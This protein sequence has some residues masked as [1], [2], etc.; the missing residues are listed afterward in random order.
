[1]TNA[2]IQAAIYERIATLNKPTAYPGVNF[3]PP[4][5]G[6]WLEVIFQPNKPVQQGLSN[7]S[8][9][10]KRGLFTV[11]V[12]GRPGN[13]VFALETL[14]QQVVEAFPK[15][16]IIGGMI[17]VSRTPYALSMQPE[18]GAMRIPVTIEYTE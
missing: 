14:T 10:A 7:D 8:Y 11:M 16:F 15:G 3:T 4:A 6:E 1:M 12:C 5:N 9:A 17:R 18:G 13:G 2:D